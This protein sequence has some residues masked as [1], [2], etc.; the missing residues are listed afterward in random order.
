MNTPVSN[1]DRFRNALQAAAAR[2]LQRTHPEY[3]A[4]FQKAL[5]ETRDVSK[6]LQAVKDISTDRGFAKWRP[7]LTATLDVEVAISRLR[8]SLNLL[9]T[10]PPSEVL[11]VFAMHSGEWVDYH[12]TA[13]IFWMHA[14]LEREKKLV[15]QAVRALVRPS[16]TQWKDIENSL[17]SSINAF[18]EHTG[19]VRDPLAHGGG[20]GVEALA[21]ERLWEGLVLLQGSLDI[22]QLLE[23]QSK[24]QAEW[25]E[26]LH[27]VSVVAIA[28]IERVFGELNRHIDWD[29]A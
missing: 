7:L 1:F 16:N 13:S 18:S 4:A 15:R 24:Y 3:V 10:P 2:A 29:N 6:A 8:N 23:S 14:L 25:Y 17:L 5:R 26:R 19:D 12:W 20:A 21:Q 28:E 27:T 22:R 11:D 9:K